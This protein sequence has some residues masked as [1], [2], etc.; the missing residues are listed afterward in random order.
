M[1]NLVLMA[2]L[3]VLAVAG[4][5]RAEADKI[6]TTLDLSFVSKYIWRGFDLMDDKASWQPSVRAAAVASAATVAK[7]RWDA[8]GIRMDSNMPERARPA[9]VCLP[10]ALLAVSDG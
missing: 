2:I 10:R 4:L 5:A 8:V 7:R 3:A 1:K 9:E 6:T